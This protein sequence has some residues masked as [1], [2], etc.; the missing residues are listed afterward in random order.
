MPTVIFVPEIAWVTNSVGV[1]AREVSIVFSVV[2][3]R[4]WFGERRLAPRLVGAGL[5]LA[6]LVCLALAR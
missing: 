6:G 1:A 3:G 5:V 4:V 2:I